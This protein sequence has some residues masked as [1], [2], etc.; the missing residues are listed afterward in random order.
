MEHRNAS[1]IASMVFR[2][3]VAVQV[4]QQNMSHV[5]HA[6]N[7]AAGASG[8]AVQRHAQKLIT[9][10]LPLVPELVSTDSVRMVKHS[11]LNR[12]TIKNV[13]QRPNDR[14]LLQH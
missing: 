12:V 14:L 3:E 10:V 2:V 7:G 11:K 13:L 9:L 1:D 8:E 6:V 5:R 4:A